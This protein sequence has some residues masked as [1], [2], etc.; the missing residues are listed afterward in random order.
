MP[1]RA[2][3]SHLDALAAAVRSVPYWGGRLQ[4][5]G[6]LAALG[7]LH[8]AVFVEPYLT[9]ILSGRKTVES[10]FSVVRCAPYERVAPGD[11][12]LLKLSG[13]PVIGVCEVRD[14]W[15][16]QLDKASW[17]ELRQ[18]FTE[19]LCAQDPKFWADRSHASFATLMSIGRVR[20]CRQL[21]GRR[22]TAVAGS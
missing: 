18:E 5:N 3:T 16:Y 21:H 9:Y 10:R 4:S 8:L 14:A 1:T 7:G 15:F 20:G 11:A 6:R 12:I 13:G 17:R 19:A 22:E 2:D